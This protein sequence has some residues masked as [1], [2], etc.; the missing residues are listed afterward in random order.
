[1]NPLR[2]TPILFSLFAA[3]SI[4]ATDDATLIRENGA[5]LF[6]DDFN[7]HE[8]T[9]D[10]EEVGNGWTTNSATRAQGAKQ[11]SLEDGA[12]HVTKAAVA[13]HGVAIFHDVAFQDGA[14]KL[15]FKLDEG[16]D[17]GIDFVDR[18]LKT[19][20]AG[21]LCIAHVT[22]K[23]IGLVDEKTGNMEN[24]VHERIEA[25]DRSPEI[26]N[27]I[28][29]KSKYFPLDLKAGEWHTLL[30]VVEGDV[31]RTTI[32]DKYIGHFQSPGMAHPTKRMITL[33]VNKSAWV[34]DVKIWSL[35]CTCESDDDS[36][37]PKPA[38]KVEAPTNAGKN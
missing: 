22:L 13:N 17:L 27:L 14:V 24:S 19:V 37:A 25:G 33:A 23:N 35:K 34:D 29:S 16:D 15:R 3:G 18:Q 30:V 10:K 31:M 32:D 20:H 9:P 36:P 5:L 38:P 11:A 12:L 26:T 4:L 7:R 8:S 2:L 28:K 21:H 1:M 6:Q